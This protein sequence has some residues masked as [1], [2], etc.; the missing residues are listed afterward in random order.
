MVSRFP[1][2]FKTALLSAAL[3]S[4]GHVTGANADDGIVVYNAQHE[5]LTKSWVE[6][7]TRQTGIKVT[8]RNGDDTEMGNQIVQEGSASPADVFLT[9]NSPAMVLVD[10]AGLLAPVAP[11][12]L[13]QVGSAY[14]PAQGKWLGIAARSTVFV[15]NPS[16]LPATEVP[17][18]LLDLAAPAW[19][20]RWAASPAGADFQA[21]VAAVLELKGEAATLDWLKGMKA[22][23]AIYRGNS[24]VLKAVNAGQVD[25]G[26]IYHYYSFVDQAKTGENSK[27][28]T[29]HY[30][31]HQDP[32]AF[33]SISG[34]GVLASSK[35][36]EQ[37]QAFLKWITG[38]DGQA[39]LKEGNSFEYAVGQNAPSNP[40][41]V[42]LTQLDA[43][44][45]DASRLDSKKAVA[46]MTQ[47]G[48][49]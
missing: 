42:P 13:E 48:L 47:A 40:K 3:I 15:F 18:S 9:E 24:A 30:F 21:I 16:K 36:P 32:G 27:D 14:R 45:V 25:S 6:G 38:K 43:P 23:A 19:K 22:N 49:L 33:V 12:T 34:G 37:A 17:A 31:K 7:F 2:L 41:L 46:L 29:L 4:A 26:V 10:N 28:T 5:S 35:H 1:S 39:V 8:V 20:G 11:P 44:K